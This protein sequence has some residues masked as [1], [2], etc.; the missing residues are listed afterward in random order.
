MA[1]GLQDPLDEAPVLDFQTKSDKIKFKHFLDARAQRS[2]QKD[3][4]PVELNPLTKNEREIIANTVQIIDP[5]PAL[6]RKALQKEGQIVRAMR[7]PKAVHCSKWDQK[8]PKKTAV[9][10]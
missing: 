9:V 2:L 1:R 4:A 5:G 7:A 10:P 8:G 3:E 6:V